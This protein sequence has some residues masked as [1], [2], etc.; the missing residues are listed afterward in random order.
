[1]SNRY[2]VHLNMHFGQI[3]NLRFSWQ[4]LWRISSCA[5]MPHSLVKTYWCFTSADSLFRVEEWLFYPDDVD[6]KFLLNISN[7]SKLNSN[8]Y[9]NTTFLNLKITEKVFNDSHRGRGPHSSQ[10]VNCVVLCIACVNCVV[11]CIVCV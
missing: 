10:L 8:T 5:V 9:Q 3:E 6:C 11:L 1:M 4:K 2:V 7:L